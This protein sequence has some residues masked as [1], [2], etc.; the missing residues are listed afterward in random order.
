MGVRPSADLPGA[1]AVYAIE[2]VVSGKVYILSSLNARRRGAIIARRHASAATQPV[3]E[4]RLDKPPFVSIT[5]KF[6]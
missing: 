1:P 6:F 5:S 3:P 2:N 4:A